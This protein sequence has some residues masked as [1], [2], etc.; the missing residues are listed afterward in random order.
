M[1]ISAKGL[2]FISGFEKEVL[3]TFNDGFDYPSIGPRINL[4]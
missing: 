4:K 3:H 2:N 1:E